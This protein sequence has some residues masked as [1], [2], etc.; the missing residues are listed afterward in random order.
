MTERIPTED[1]ITKY[2]AA[3]L[4]DKSPRTIDRYISDGT[5]PPLKYHNGRV[6]VRRSDVLALLTPAPVDSPLTRESA[7][8]FSV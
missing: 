4:L 2:E 5:L 8:A 3:D 7:G 6:V 1:L